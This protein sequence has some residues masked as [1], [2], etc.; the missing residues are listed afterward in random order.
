MRIF[1]ALDCYGLARVD[2][3]VKEDGEVIFNEI[4]TLPGFT[5]ISMYP[6]LW[7]ARGI[8][9][10]ELVEKLID[11]VTGDVYEV[12]GQQ[13][14]IGRERAATDVTL[15]DPNVSRRHAQLT[16]TGQDWSIEDLNSTNGTLVNNRRVTRCPLRSGDMVTFGLSTFEF[17]G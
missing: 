6:K 12:T 11:V 3:F 17:R 16:Y 7:E 9:P 13:C 14:V 5:A 2:F 8:A 15:R 10:T 4:N 1:N